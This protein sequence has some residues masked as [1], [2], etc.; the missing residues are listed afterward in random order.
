MP[1]ERSLGGDKREN[2]H[3]KQHNHQAPGKAVVAGEHPGYVTDNRRDEHQLKNKDRHAGN[4]EVVGKLVFTAFDGAQD[5][6][7]DSQRAKQQSYLVVIIKKAK[8]RDIRNK[9]VANCVEDLIFNDNGAGSH[10][11]Q[12]QRAA[13]NQPGRHSGDK[14]RHAQLGNWR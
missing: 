2:R 9:T 3:D 10:C 1:S 11:Y 13:E 4:F 8:I 6:Q 12:Q 5:E 7:D 14:G